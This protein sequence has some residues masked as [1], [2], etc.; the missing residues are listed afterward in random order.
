MT[1]NYRTAPSVD[2]SCRLDV[3]KVE[4]LNSCQYNAYDFLRR[5]CFSILGGGKNFTAC[6]HV[7]TGSLC[8]RPYSPGWCTISCLWYGD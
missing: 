3:K 6:H 5:R 2:I 1:A 8:Q 7:E 4:E